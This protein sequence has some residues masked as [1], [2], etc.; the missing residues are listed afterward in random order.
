VSSF[1][2]KTY[3][4]SLRCCSSPAIS[5]RIASHWV[6]SGTV[7]SLLVIHLSRISEQKA[8][9]LNP[10]SW[11]VFQLPPPDARLHKYANNNDIPCCCYIG[12]SCHMNW[13][14]RRRRS[15]LSR[16]KDYFP[17]GWASTTTTIERINI[18]RRTYFKKKEIFIAALWIISK[19]NRKRKPWSRFCRVYICGICC[20]CSLIALWSELCSFSV[21]IKLR[22]NEFIVNLVSGYPCLGP[23]ILFYPYSQYRTLTG[24]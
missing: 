3:T 7:L 17:S 14:R 19:K 15:K 9:I 11:G 1:W 21:E 10:S 5:R 23:W 18:C 20:I 12:G 4:V 8:F 16:H 13:L 2:V 22:K 6:A 24:P